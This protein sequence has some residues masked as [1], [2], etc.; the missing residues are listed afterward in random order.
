[1][2]N[3]LNSHHC[4]QIISQLH[5]QSTQYTDYLRDVAIFFQN[6]LAFLAN[7]TSL[8][9]V[10]YDESPKPASQLYLSIFLNRGKDCRR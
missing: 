5:K 10:D 6:A 7:P 4:T 1:M 2:Q 8:L 3:L 9:S